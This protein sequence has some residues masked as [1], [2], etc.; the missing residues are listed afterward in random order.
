MWRAARRAV[1]VEVDGQR[2]ADITGKWSMWDRGDG[3]VFRRSI[4]GR[5]GWAAVSLFD[6]RREATRRRYDLCLHMARGYWLKSEG[7]ATALERC[8]EL[9]EWAKEAMR[10]PPAERCEGFWAGLGGG[11]RHG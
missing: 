11:G 4:P 6:L 1:A 8:P 2:Y 5:S 3:V 10:E 9:L 7:R